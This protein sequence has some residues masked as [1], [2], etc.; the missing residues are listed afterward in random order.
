[1]VQAY[2]VT[3]TV[4]DGVTV[5]LDEAIPM[6]AGR[7]RVF[8]EPIPVPVP[9]TISDAIAIIRERQRLRGHVP[10]SREEIDAYLR[11]ERES[12]DD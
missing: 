9:Q 3:G 12:W 10:A 2:M 8:V 4:T 1:M 7:V 11:A 6:T 5:R